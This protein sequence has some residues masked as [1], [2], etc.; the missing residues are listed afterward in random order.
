M[1]SSI[2]SGS[3]GERAGTRTGPAGPPGNGRRRIMTGTGPLLLLTLLLCL[4]AGMLG[5]CSSVHEDLELQ[6][7]LVPPGGGLGRRARGDAQAENYAAFGDT[8]YINLD[9]AMLG[10]AATDEELSL[11]NQAQ[12]VA[13]DGTIWVPLVGRLPVEGLTERQIESLIE[14]KLSTY[15][16]VKIDLS[17][18][19]LN[20]GGKVFFVFGEVRRKGVQ[21]FTRGDMT[22]LD[23]VAMADPTPV[24]NLGKVKVIRADPSHPQVITVNVREIIQKGYSGYNI[25]IKEDDI[26]YVPPTF[27]GTVGNFLS[28]LTYPFQS[29]F[30]TAFG[31]VSLGWSYRWLTGNNDYYYGGIF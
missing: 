26:I 27:L 30:S 9:P 14:Q 5:G 4:P 3:G 20:T 7:L 22:V 6:Q 8:I 12:T 29:L 31:L 18:R 28:R 13:I 25:N 17:V 16:K 24:A 10:L 15:Y 11:L 2:V 19:I 23:V 1:K 21:V